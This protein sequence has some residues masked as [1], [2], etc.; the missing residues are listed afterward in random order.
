MVYFRILPP[1]SHRQTSKENLHLGPLGK[2][3]AA[4]IG[5][6]V[7]FFPPLPIFAVAVL[8][9]HIWPYE[10]SSSSRLLRVLQ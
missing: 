8:L 4:Y 7:T 6:L 2:L 9:L 3:I 5:T 1:Y 10:E